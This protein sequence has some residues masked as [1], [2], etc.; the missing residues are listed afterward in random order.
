[1]KFDNE[2]FF[3]NLLKKIQVWLNYE[4]RVLYVKT[5]VHLL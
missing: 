1:M 4:L 3:K 2:V 5:Y